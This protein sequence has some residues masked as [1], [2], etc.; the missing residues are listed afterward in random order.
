M[1]SA[2]NKLHIRFP[3]LSQGSRDTKQE[4]IGFFEAREIRRGTEYTLF[5]KNS[6][7][8]RRNMLD[9]TFPFMELANFIR[10]KIKAQN[11]NA[12]T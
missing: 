3:V 12:F 8:I 6:Q 4:N 9:I 10:V 7:F 11:R 1:G 5:H 2:F